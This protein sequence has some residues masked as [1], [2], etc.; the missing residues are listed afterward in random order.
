MGPTSMGAPER[1]SDDGRPRASQPFATT[2]LGPADV[3]NTPNVKPSFEEP[4]EEE[5]EAQE[6]FWIGRTLSNLYV[7]EQRI[8]EGGM[9]TVYVAR[10]VHL[11]KRFAVKVLNDAIVHR[12]NAV[13]RL[14]QEAVAASS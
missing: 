2:A 14:K 6:D 10:H 4:E 7:L 11:E 5:E 1:E 8:G 9:G 3:R 12:N 13:E